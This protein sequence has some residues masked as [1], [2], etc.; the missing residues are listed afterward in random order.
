MDW[1]R[2]SDNDFYKRITGKLLLARSK[3]NVLERKAA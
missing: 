3:H 2:K 1:Y